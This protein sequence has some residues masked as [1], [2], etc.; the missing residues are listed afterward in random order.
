MQNPL[1]LLCSFEGPDTYSQAG[2]LGVRIS[3]LAFA[4]GENGYETHLFFIGDPQKAGEEKL[5][6]GKLIYHRWCQ[7]I[8]HYHPMGV[9]DGE[10]GKIRDYA[11]SLPHAVVNKLIIPA[12]KDNRPIVVMAEEW[13]TVPMIF[14]LSHQLYQMGLRDKVVL[15]WNANNV[16]GFNRI[17]WQHLASVCTIT[18]V[19]RFMK[20]LMWQLG[21]N[22]IVIPNGISNNWLCVLPKTIVQAF[23]RLIKNRFVMVKV[24]RFDPDKRWLMAIEAGAML[25]QQGLPSALKPLFIFRGGLEP[26]GGEVRERAKLLGLQIEPVYYSKSP[27]LEECL[28]GLKAAIQTA[29]LV[30]IC[31]FV[32]ADFLKLLY[33]CAN[34]VLAASGMEP[35][36]LVGL[37]VMGSG[38]VAVTGCTGEDYAIPF[39][40]A[41]VI[42]TD[43]PIELSYSMKFLAENPELEK[44]IRKEGQK[45]AKNFLW[46][47]VI[48]LLIEKIG[49]AA[50]LQKVNLANNNQILSNKL[51]NIRK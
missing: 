7:W 6:D 17:P 11:A 13:H 38:G 49:F 18:T 42:E 28:E 12:V 4:L 21:V 36:G 19:S 48:N 37:E 34:A 8:S 43:Y 15:L 50:N 29:D 51:Q 14:S 26:H 10:E 41:I 33:K 27:S 5:L 2:G 23:S 47:N 39:Q 16:F 9:Y 1:F 40:N 22:P 35:F 24:G 31:S 25:K 30:E 44:S 46:E 32:P 20:H 3:D 45:T